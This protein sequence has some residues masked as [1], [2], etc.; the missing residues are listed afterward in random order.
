MPSE[1]AALAWDEAVNSPEMVRTR[2]RAP[3]PF[4]ALLAHELRTPLTAILTSLQILQRHRSDGPVAERTRA[5]VER[6]AR[7]IG[8]LVDDL[9]DVFRVEQGKIQL[10]KQRLHLAAAVI[11]AVESVSSLIEKQHHS[12][13]VVLP[14]EPLYLEADPMRL[15]QILVNLLT[16]AAKYTPPGGQIWLAVEHGQDEVVLRVWDTGIGIATDMLPSIF[17]L[18]VQEKTGSQGGLGIGL[19]LVRNLVRLHGGTVTASSAGP[20]QGSE[21]VVRLPLLGDLGQADFPLAEMAK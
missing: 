1:A 11:D 4:L 7:H 12:L 3:D 15:E 18:F 21:F 20:G 9:L 17:D 2:S 8:R 6:Q 19:H 16:N 10:R 14:P 13:E 5:I